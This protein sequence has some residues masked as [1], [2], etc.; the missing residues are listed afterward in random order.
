MIT[1]NFHLENIAEVDA[2]LSRIPVAISAASEKILDEAGAVILHRTKQR[3]LAEKDPDDNPWP[4]ST[5]GIIRRSGGYT[6]SSRTGRRYTG[7]GTLYET[8][9]L[10]Q[11]IQYFRPGPGKREIG[12]DVP[13]AKNHQN[14][15][16]V[17]IRRF[18]G[19]SESDQALLKDIVLRNLSNLNLSSTEGGE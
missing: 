7:T 2:A 1:V 6:R 13:Y 15:I 14:G 19:V 10:F 9:L 18:L 4:P 8:G 11:S 12:T 5:R 17:T 3:F 16:G